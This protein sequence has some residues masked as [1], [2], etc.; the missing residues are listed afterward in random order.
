M[1]VMNDPNYISSRATAF[2]E[3]ERERDL[4]LKRE[5]R[6]EYKEGEFERVRDSQRTDYAIAMGRAYAE[7]QAREARQAVATAAAAAAA[8]P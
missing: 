2:A 4:S 6:N 3:Y 7:F 5:E 1:N 8:L